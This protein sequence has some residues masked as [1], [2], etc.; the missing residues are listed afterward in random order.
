[1]TRSSPSKLPGYRELL[2]HQMQKY[3]NKHG[4]A[5]F[6]RQ[7]EVLEDV[8]IRI[9][10]GCIEWIPDMLA[11]LEETV[12]VDDLS[13]LAICLMGTLAHVNALFRA[14]LKEEIASCHSP[15]SSGRTAFA[16]HLFETTFG[17][18]SVESHFR[19]LDV[20]AAIGFLGLVGRDCTVPMIKT[21]LDIGIYVDVKGE[22]RIKNILGS[23]AAEGNMGA[24]YAL[25]EAGANSSFA[26][27]PFLNNSKH[28]SDEDFRRIL[29]FLVDNARFTT[30]YCDP[31]L[32]IL[33]SSRALSS[34]PE[35]PKIL[36]DRKLFVQGRFGHGA[37]EPY[38][39]H[40][41]M[42]QAILRRNSSV[43]DF[44]LRN[45]AN[46]NA[47]ISDSFRCTD[48]WL[49]SCTWITFSAICGA[50]TCTDVLIHHGADVT[51]LDG[52][53]RSALRLA[54]DL[55]LGSHPRQLGDFGCHYFSWKYGG[56]NY[57]GWDCVAA[58]EDAE[59]LA[60]V[61]RAFNDKFQGTMTLEDYYNSNE[62]N[63]GENFPHLPPSQGEPAS[64]LQKTFD[65]ALTT[66]LTP[67][68]IKLLHRRLRY[69]SH[70]IRKIWSRSFYETLLIRFIYVLSYALLLTFELHALIKGHKR[71]QMPSR[72]FISALAVLA[73]ALMWGSSLLGYSWESIVVGSNR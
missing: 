42:F 10:S 73:L 19:K 60:V 13:S 17:P 38:Y 58:Q 49:Q 47:Q 11:H 66:I 25:V 2:R 71:L 46:A 14:Q 53:G 68:Q 70:E 40:S 67:T 30:S 6:E 55:A 35:A 64:I 3:S 72:H 52:A 44:L 51:T 65:K 15:L 7:S 27:E 21:F 29:E 56:C 22:W 59:T 32:A 9:G 63:N 1:M 4:G 36:L 33:R 31:L 23:A 43:V 20:D 39:Y 69:H 26:V 50:A 5:I 41:Y 12:L 37:P 54:K 8:F 61:E 16:D 24:L 57:L 48:G 62:G 45:G 18:A 28:F 34:Y